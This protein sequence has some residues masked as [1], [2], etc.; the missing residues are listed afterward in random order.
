MYDPI[1]GKVSY[2]STNDGNNFVVNSPAGMLTGHLLKIGM[3]T[4]ADILLNGKQTTITSQ[5]I[6]NTNWLDIQ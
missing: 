2:P 5:Q 3:F 1:T 6:G 4:V